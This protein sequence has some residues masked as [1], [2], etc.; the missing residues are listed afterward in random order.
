MCQSSIWGGS[1]ALGYG[2]T[3]ISSSGCPFCD[4][5]EVN[6]TLSINFWVQGGSS[7][8][9]FFRRSVAVDVQWQ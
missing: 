2:T 6:G 9:Q 1:W 8:I 7:M 3:G 5:R 4:A